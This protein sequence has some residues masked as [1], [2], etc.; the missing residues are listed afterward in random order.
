VRVV[1]AR[2][3]GLRMCWR[4]PHCNG[5]DWERHWA[6]AS[7]S[8]RACQNK[9]GKNAMPLGGSWGMCDSLAAGTEHQGEGTP[10]LHGLATIV[11]PYQHKSLQEI[12]L[13]IE[14]DILEV[15]SVKAFQEHLCSE[16]HV[17]HEA[18][19]AAL[20]ELE[21]AWK[22]NHAGQEHVGL[23]AKPQYQHEDYAADLWASHGQRPSGPHTGAGRPC[24]DATLEATAA[25]V[26]RARAEAELY[27][28]EFEA[29]VQYVFSRVQHHWHEEVKGK[30]VP[31]K[32]CRVKGRQ[33]PHLCK[34]RFPKTKQLSLSAKV[35]CKGLALRHGLRVSGRRNALGSVLSRRRSPWLSGTSRLFAAVFRSNTHTGPSFRVPLTA[36][37]HECEGACLT[38][39]VSTKRLAV[40]TQRAMR[41]MVGYF[42]GYI[43]KR[44]PAGRYEMKASTTNLQFLAEKLKNQKPLTQVA[45]VTNRMFSDL[46]SKGV[47]RSAPEEFNLA[48][49]GAKQDQLDA[50]FV[51]TFES[52]EFVGVS[53]LQRLR[54]V[55][56]GGQESSSARLPRRTRL[57]TATYRCPAPLVDLYGY[58]GTDARVYHLS[59]W[60]FSAH[61]YPH[62]LQPPSAGSRAGTR[63]TP[64]G[65]AE[66]QESRESAE[67]FEAEPGEHYVVDEAWFGGEACPYESDNVVILADIPEL[68]RFRHEWVLLRSARPKVPCPE[69]TPLP[70]KHQTP[71]ERAQLCSVYLRPWV[72]TRRGASEH[73][74]FLADLDIVARDASQPV[75]RRRL[76]TKTSAAAA[77][78]IVRSWRRTWKCYVRGRVVSRYAA[79]IVQNF[80][81]AVSAEGRHADRKDEEDV[82]ELKSVL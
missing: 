13:M 65:K 79:Q 1:L 67:V 49:H 18:H 61:W 52:V 37:T 11:C 51:R 59:P 57:D 45:T 53:Y 25:E 24:E 48:A 36:K 75:T 81:M 55:Q 31:L 22:T 35:L 16:D 66:Y 41:Q 30:R 5:G 42:S 82:E 6:K 64:A 3:L 63:W 71:E 17:A 54:V 56:R 2:L 77:S 4:C 21:A 58:R 7:D 23:C 47:L 69:Q 78:G 9:F 38:T 72:L 33:S 19:A 15:E 46:E 14:R 62:Q 8:L 26:G 29:D 80:L 73:V 74:P 68:Q 43:S 28:A 60:E 32:Y 10:H 40:C 34:A 20:P 44:Q 50:E 39:G 70:S 27:K 12:A 76:E